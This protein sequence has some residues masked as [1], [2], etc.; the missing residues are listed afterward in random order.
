M[1]ALVTG[2]TGFVGGAIV[3]ELLR[4]G[5]EVRV[6]AR[7]V[8]NTAA[9]E[10]LGVEITRGNILDGGSLAAALAGRDVLFHAAAIYEFWTPDRAAL[11]RTEIEGTRNALEAALDAG[12]SRVVYTSTA[13]CLGEAR[14]AVATEE[15][16]HRGY[17]LSP[18]E[19]AKYGA[20]LVAKQYRD[21]L[22]VAIIKPAGVLGPGDLKPSG[23]SIVA[24]IN[25][26]FPALFHGALTFVAVSDVALGHVLAA[27]QEKFGEDYILA[28]EVLT[29]AEFYGVIAELAGVKRPPL[30][31]G[32]LVDL[33]AGYEE[34]KARRTGRVPL[35]S[36]NAFRTTAHGFRADGSKA[37]RELGLT[38][39]PIRDTLRDAINWYWKQGLLTREPACITGSDPLLANGR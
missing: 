21:R 38:Y 27:E 23:T 28:A 6:L 2:G 36:K 22:G 19:E 37:A 1:K 16:V 18:Y 39:T 33:F 8:S 24:L 20:E 15:T 7:S 31:P 32:L 30:I 17:F 3:R 9:L 25:G 34:W 29:T 5:H 4:R 14:G 12:V 13:V 11:M 10:A 26:R 35:I